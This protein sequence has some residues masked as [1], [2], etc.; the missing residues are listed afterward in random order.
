ME[1][2]NNKIINSVRARYLIIPAVILVLLLASVPARAAS[3]VINEFLADPA[4][5]I[6]GDAN[7]DGLSSSTQDEFVELVNSSDTDLDISGWLISDSISTT[8]VFPTG[9][10]LS[11]GAAIVV[12]GGGTPT[13]EFG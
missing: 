10:V 2:V 9:T 1:R 12:F 13:G 7:G 8:H 4:T 6:L 3:I 11:P 5:G